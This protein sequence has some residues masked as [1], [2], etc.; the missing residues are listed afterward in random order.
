MGLTGEFSRGGQ[1]GKELGGGWRLAGPP[2]GPLNLL[3]QVEVGGLGV[4]TQAL[5]GDVGQTCWNSVFLGPFRQVPP[6]PGVQQC[7]ACSRL[8]D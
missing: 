5:P 3:R 2:Q 7:L 1:M 4:G 6:S 8:A